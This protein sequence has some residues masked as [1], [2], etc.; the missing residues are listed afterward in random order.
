MHTPNY[1][2]LRSLPWQGHILVAR[3]LLLA[4]PNKSLASVPFD[5]GGLR[6]FPNSV[7]VVDGLYDIRQGKA[8]R[9]S[10]DALTPR[11]DDVVQSPLLV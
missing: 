11:S 10:D 2:R 3:T 6:C 7:V 9:A 1:A 8:V 5:L 4:F